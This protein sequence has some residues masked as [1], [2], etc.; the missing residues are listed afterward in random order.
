MVVIANPAYDVVFK[1]LMEDNKIA[2]LLL[3]DLLHEEIVEL[4]FRPQEY[5]L[6]VIS[7]TVYRLDFKAKI[8]SADGTEKV[9]LIEVQ[10]AKFPTDIVR[11]RKYVGEQYSSQQN[12]IEI[13]KKELKALPIITVY[14]LGYNLESNPQYP[15]VRVNRTVVDNSTGEKIEIKDVFIESLTHD[16]IIV[17][18]PKLKKI[19][20]NELEM[21]LSLFDE[22][23]DK[24][25]LIIDESIYPDRYKGIIERLKRAIMASEIRKNMEVE[26]E[27][28]KSFK[29][30]EESKEMLQQ[31]LEQKERKLKQKE[32]ELKQEKQKAEQ[33][34]EKA[35]QEKQRAEQEKV[36]IIRKLFDK[37]FSIDEVM[38]TTK[39]DIEF[40]KKHNLIP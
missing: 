10:K 19:R 15:V 36:A 25:E 31:E 17:Q 39:T 4:E 32:K 2:K 30:V 26:D 34:K 6:E 7:L 3:S 13:E 35:E 23:E 9:V 12:I 8:K 29:L 28:I 20:R 27:V 33:E 38:E 40:L 37:G 1:Y 14:F 5:S 24:Q 18:I 16:C 11:F 21:I 22:E